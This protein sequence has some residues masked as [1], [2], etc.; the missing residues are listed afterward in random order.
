MLSYF[1]SQLEVYMEKGTDVSL[2]VDV[3]DYNAKARLERVLNK[4]DILH[5]FV[6]WQVGIIVLQYILG[7][8]QIFRVL[9]L[10]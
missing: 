9:L 3:A 10:L 5:F 6:V 2:V 7:H 1:R 8:F 4:R